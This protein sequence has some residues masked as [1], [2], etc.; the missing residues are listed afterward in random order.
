MPPKFLEPLG[1]LELPAPLVSIGAW[2]STTLFF[3]WLLT[4]REDH[5]GSPAN[6]RL[7][8]TILLAVSVVALVLVILKRWAET[9]QKVHREDQENAK[10]RLGWN[11]PTTTGAWLVAMVILVVVG[12]VAAIAFI[13]AALVSLTL[14]TGR[15]PELG[16]HR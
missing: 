7:W 5:P 6:G 3:A 14:Y 8:L 10:W 4:Q 16:E 11:R 15:F 13:F 9:A 2:A 1:R 12:P